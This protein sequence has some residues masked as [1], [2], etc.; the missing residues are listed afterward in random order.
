M[1][2]KY[3]VRI[4]WGIVVQQNNA[5]N[6][7]PI[8]NHKISIWR[9]GKHTSGK[10]KKIGQIFLT[11]NNLRVMIIKDEPLKFNRRHEYQPMKR[12]LD[13]YVSD[14]LLNE[15]RESSQN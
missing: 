1:K 5:G 9:I 2:N 4:F 10:F 6:Y 3:D 15:F 14:E 11:E 8:D 12:F 7:Q 13:D